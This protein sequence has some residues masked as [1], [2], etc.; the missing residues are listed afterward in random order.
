MR[1]ALTDSQARIAKVGSG[2]AALLLLSLVAVPQWEGGSVFADD[3]SLLL[4]LLMCAALYAAGRRR[5]RTSLALSL[6]L[7]AAFLF[8]VGSSKLLASISEAT[9]VVSLMDALL[10]LL[11]SLFGI[12]IGIYSALLYFKKEE[13][14]S[15]E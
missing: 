13:I 12:M 9:L 8:T 7:I 5:T 11:G 6:V 15:S 1:N 14:L 4:G 2:V 10:G 3:P